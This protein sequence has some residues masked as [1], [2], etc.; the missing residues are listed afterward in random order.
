MA[1]YKPT[2]GIIDWLG[3]HPKDAAPKISNEPIM[4]A[5]Q[6]II[7]VATVIGSAI[8]LQ[9]A[10]AGAAAPPNPPNFTPLAVGFVDYRAACPYG[11]HYACWYQPYGSRFCGCWQGGDRPACP[12]DY[13]YACRLGPEGYPSCGCY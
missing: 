13:H 2:G 4:R 5:L 7:A 9:P 10:L 6:K 11:Q 3:P 1:A 12:L 8:P